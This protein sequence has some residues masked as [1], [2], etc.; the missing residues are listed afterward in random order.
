MKSYFDFVLDPFNIKP[1]PGGRVKMRISE[2]VKWYE[3]SSVRYSH[4][5]MG[6]LAGKRVLDIGC[7]TGAHLVWLAKNGAIPTGIDISD[8]RVEAAKRLVEEAGLKDRVSVYVRN[9]EDTGFEDET[10]DI[11]CGQDVLMFLG[12]DFTAFMN[13][14]KRILKKRGSIV[15]SEAMD[16]HPVARVYRRYLAPSEWKQFTH[17]F[18]LDYIREIEASFGSVRYKTF[19]LTGFPVYLLKMYVPIYGLFCLLDGMFDR[20]D[21]SITKVFPFLKKYCWRIVFQASKSG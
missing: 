12:G 4:N 11:I 20:V 2:A 7:G 9:G 14:A 15:F 17:Y 5:C 6:P 21:S 10:F 1:G 18:N 8:R 16:L 13:E 3:D 19:Y